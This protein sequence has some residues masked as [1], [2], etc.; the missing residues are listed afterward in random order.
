[1]ILTPISQLFPRW[2]EINEQKFKYKPIKIS[3]NKYIFTS[4][5]PEIY[6]SISD[7]EKETSI[8]YSH[9]EEIYDYHD[10][11]YIKQLVYVLNKG[12]RDKGEISESEKR[13]YPSFKLLV[14]ENL[15]EGITH[16]CDKYFVEQ[17]HYFLV[18]LGTSKLAFIGNEYDDSIIKELSELIPDEETPIE[19]KKNYL[20]NTN[21]G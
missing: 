17:N 12:F 21:N 20:F 13:Y 10:I 16:F 1:M 6:L 3:N 9:D 7:E 18:N 11:N 19:I 2:L 4:I 14:Y 5:N 8:H 15:F